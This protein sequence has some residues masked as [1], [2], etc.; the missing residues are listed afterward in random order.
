MRRFF[1]LFLFLHSAGCLFGQTT[2]VEWNFPNDPDDAI[3]D[4]AIPLNAAKTVTT[5][6]ANAPTF[7]PAGATTNSSVATN[8]ITGAT[9]KYWQV[10]VTTTGYNTITLSSKQRSTTTGPRDF[11]LEYRIG[12]AGLWTAIPGGAVVTADD[13]ASG[14]LTN[15]ALPAACNDQPSVFIRWIMSTNTAVNL[16]AV[17]GGGNSNIDDI[18][19]RG[20]LIAGAALPGNYYRTVQSGTWDDASTWETSVDNIIWTPTAV[21]PT[22]AANAITINTTHIVTINNTTSA[23][24]L[25]IN[26]G[27]SLV[28]NA[29]VAFSLFDAA[30][31]DM[32]ILGSYTINGTMPSGT[33][34]IRVEPNGSVFAQTN[35]APNES[36]DFAYSPRVTFANLSNFY[37]SGGIFDAVNITY[38][39]NSGPNDRPRFIIY[40]NVGIV[41]SASQTTIN[42]YLDV[43]ANITFQS[44]GTKTFRDGIITSGGAILTQ[45]NTSGQ[46]IMNGVFANLGG[47]G[48]IN[49]N[50]PGLVLAVGSQG[51]LIANQQIDNS[52][53]TVN[54]EL[55]AYEYQ[56]TGST[57]FNLAG[58]LYT[59]HANGISLTGTLANGGTKVLGANSIVVYDRLLAEGDQQFTSRADYAN[60]YIY[61]GS[62][63]VLNGPSTMS[64]LLSL[65]NGRV[66]TSTANLLTISAT[67]SSL[68]GS[69]NSYVTGPL[70][71]IGNTG[72]VF[73]VG[74][75]VT[76]TTDH[77]RTISISA[78]DDVADEFTAEFIRGNARLLGGGLITAGGLQRV[79]QCE[80]WTL[81]H[82]NSGAGT[83]VNVT[84]GWTAQSPCNLSYV[85]DLPSLV[86][87]H[88]D[89]ASWDSYGGG[90]SA[91]GAVSPGP[92]TITWNAVN[93]FSPFALGTTSV[94]LNPLPLD[95]SSFS[96]R[97]K[98]MEVVID[99]HVMNNDEQEEYILE[100][101]RD[102]VN[103]EL[104]RKVPAK[105][106]LNQAAYTEVDLHPLKGW[107]YYRLRAIDKMDREKTS[108]TVKVWF[109]LNEVIRISPNPASEKI[110]INLSEPSSI[111]EI[112]LVNISGQVLK[113]INNIQFYTELNISH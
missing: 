2:L 109:G 36:D 73:P 8:W 69:A 70:R 53:F 35:A 49:L 1:T 58:T 41:G 104:L 20:F 25:T 3:A 37:W 45:S 54:G 28:H 98:N 56:I 62:Q 88:F 111:T 61:G 107:N 94:A 23:N 24:K 27:G 47:A 43:R 65:N 33:S 89:G 95:L 19:I 81:D 34:T 85:T 63:K 108:F 51:G 112:E 15:I 91:A 113:K 74:K 99:W 66:V 75:F 76:S 68:G 39:P 82:I 30:G 42:G 40:S 86:I 110:V 29:G 77:Y 18:R 67:G 11:I 17:T 93:V 79:S 12:A 87:A 46:F 44:G 97:A 21:V 96:A 64:G 5:V 90:G 31:T 103:F 4:V 48:I 7:T 14:V 57:N 10:E 78:P 6:G 84:I 83:S 106:I 50:G 71:K 105:V 26:A 92:G 60:V 22:D 59:R 101:S 13:Y 38:F 100:R 52:T 32:T 80:Y 9:T 72:F 102:G 55:F 16:A